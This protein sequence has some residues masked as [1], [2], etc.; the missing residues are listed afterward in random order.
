MTT[1][2]SLLTRLRK[3]EAVGV[4]PILKKL[5]GFEQFESEIAARVAD[6]RMSAEDGPF[7]AQCLRKWADIKNY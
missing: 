3:L 5:G 2:R 4:N 1:A 6:G 7:I